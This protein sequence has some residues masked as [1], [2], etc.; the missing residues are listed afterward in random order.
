MDKKNGDKQSLDQFSGSSYL[1]MN[2]YSKSTIRGNENAH[3]KH[4]IKNYGKEAKIQ[5]QYN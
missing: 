4:I 3:K 2:H 1:E 5:V